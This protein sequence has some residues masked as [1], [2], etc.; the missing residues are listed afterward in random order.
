[1][2]KYGN[3][4]YVPLLLAAILAQPQIVSAKDEKPR[5]KTQTQIVVKDMHC[6]A[7]AKKI[8]RKLYAVKG[9]KGV[10][11]VMKTHTATVT[12]ETGKQ[13]SPRA[14]WKAVEKAGFKPVK[15]VGPLGEFKK[16][17]KE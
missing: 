15:L 2:L 4:L 5:K 17:P 3:L 7:C 12:P 10:R 9:V 6:A 16:T 1:M 11:A 13:P 8:A 14:L